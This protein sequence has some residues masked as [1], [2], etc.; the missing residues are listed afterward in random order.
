MSLTT[1]KSECGERIAF[2]RRP[3]PYIFHLSKEMYCHVD[4]G[5]I[6]AD[7]PVSRP[8]FG[9]NVQPWLYPSL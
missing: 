8:W 5:F 4:R 3:A 1:W 7:F 6:K 9:M 2:Y